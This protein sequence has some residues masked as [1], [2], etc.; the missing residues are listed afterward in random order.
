[1]IELNKKYNVIGI[2]LMIL[3]CLFLVLFAVGIKADHSGK[4]TFYLYFLILLLPIIL[5][6]LG[7]IKNDKRIKNI[8]FILTILCLVFILFLLTTLDR[9]TYSDIG[10][11][12]TNIKTIFY[13]YVV[14][15]FGQFL[16]FA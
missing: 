7:I 4:G 14:Y 1:M 13:A 5:S 9:P 2:A 10:D 15:I 3:S 16:T 8:S 11:L 6:L 12:E